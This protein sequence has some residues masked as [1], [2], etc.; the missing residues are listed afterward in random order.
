MHYLRI[1]Y[2]L[3]IET[4]EFVITT[5]TKSNSKLNTK[6]KEAWLLHSWN[7]CPFFSLLNSLDASPS[8]MQFV[9]A[10]RNEIYIYIFYRRKMAQGPASGL[11]LSGFIYWY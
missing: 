1:S 10:I 8:W 6:G 2:F 3:S 11:R 4:D 5:P 9:E 7:V